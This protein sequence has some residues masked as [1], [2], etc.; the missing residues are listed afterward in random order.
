MVF[1]GFIYEKYQEGGGMRDLEMI[2]ETY[3]DAFLAAKKFIV[4]I[5]KEEAKRIYSEF[6]QDFI[7]LND[8]EFLNW[9][10][11]YHIENIIKPRISNKEYTKNECDFTYYY[12]YIICERNIQIFDTET[13]NIWY[14]STNC[15]SDIKHSG[16]NIDDY[17][18]SNV[19]FPGNF[20]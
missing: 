12:R 2:A 10:Y 11:K 15:G 14:Y 17:L 8:D 3:T 1:L 20:S 16:K 18:I 7:N 9:L 19:F 13:H 5:S 4:N 6:Y